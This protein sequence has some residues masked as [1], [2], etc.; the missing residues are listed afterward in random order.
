MKILLLAVMA[1]S[2]ANGDFAA[3]SN[4]AVSTDS[5]EAKI[6][7]YSRALKSW[8]PRDGDHNKAVVLANRAAIRHQVGDFEGAIKD[9]TASMDV[10]GKGALTLANRGAALASLGRHSE[11]VSDFTEA[12]RHDPR[13]PTHYASRAIAHDAMGKTE[14]AILDYNVLLSIDP[15]FKEGRKTRGSLL[16]KAGRYAEAVADFDAAISLNRNDRRAYQLK[17]LAEEAIAQTKKNAEV[18]VRN[19]EM[20]RRSAAQSR[21]R[22]QQLPFKMPDID[23]R[24]WLFAAGLL[25]LGFGI[26]ALK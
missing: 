21:Q 5:P 14:Q 26:R 15:A 13:N 24:I 18:Q 19:E 12:I 17:A 7:L 8:T 3:L 2:A 10:L 22:P 1:V 9:L 20:K 4:R 11:A 6:E 16:F 23:P 25:L